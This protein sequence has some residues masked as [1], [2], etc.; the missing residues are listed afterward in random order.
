MS[1]SADMAF[2]RFFLRGANC[3]LSAIDYGVNG[4]P[5][6]VIVHG[7]RDHG[8]SLHSVA[9]AFADKFHVV[10][11]DLRGHGDSD[12]CG[13]YAMV[14]FIADLRALVIHCELKH[15]VLIGHSL[16]GHIVS[17]Y[18]AI[19]TGEVARLV[20]IDG[21]GPPRSPQARSAKMLQQVWRDNVDNALALSS[22]RRQMASKEAALSRLKQNN[23]LLAESTA[24]RIVDH[25][26]EPHPDGGV[27]WKW[28]PAVNMVWSTFEHG[29]SELQWTL[30]NCPVLVITG[31]NS[32]A[33]WSGRNL[34]AHSDDNVHRQETERRVALFRDAVHV[35][36]KGAGHMIHYDQPEALNQSLSDF[37]AAG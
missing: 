23:P 8:V 5:D 2:K 18:A 7:M 15:P 17:K 9:T 26:V 36:I 35:E 11:P 22:V 3:T 12:N 31:E 19:Y 4:M 10:V 37:L 28:D 14:Q 29:E 13:S 16:G 32:M 34:S 33:Y 21:M 30:V 24:E 1:R 6:L 27:Q 20:L 25:G